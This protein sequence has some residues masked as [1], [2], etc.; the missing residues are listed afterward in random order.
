[1]PGV[2]ADISRDAIDLSQSSAQQH[3]EKGR[4]IQPGLVYV[5]RIR[6]LANSIRAGGEVVPL[7]PGMSV[8]AEIKTGERRIIQVAWLTS[9][10]EKL[11]KTQRGATSRLFKK[12]VGGLDRR[13]GAG[14]DRNAAHLD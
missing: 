10:E 14:R 7:G 1:M 3:D 5:A 11:R 13:F 8:Q 9:E 6:L 2:V 12:I 4:P